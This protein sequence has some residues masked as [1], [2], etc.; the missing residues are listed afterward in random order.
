M[1]NASNDNGFF[2]SYVHPESPIAKD[3]MDFS[4]DAMLY[5]TGVKEF[6]YKDQPDLQPVA[7][8]KDTNH[9]SLIQLYNQTLVD[10]AYAEYGIKMEGKCQHCKKD[11]TLGYGM[12]VSKAF[13]M[14]LSGSIY[15]SPK[16]TKDLTE[17]LYP[18]STSNTGIDEPE[19]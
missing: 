16:S 4:K 15:G 11:V 5:G 8:P 13:Q 19:G 10:K 7:P 18:E 6:K 3:A 1:D 14:M 17:T 9:P 2:K 12:Q